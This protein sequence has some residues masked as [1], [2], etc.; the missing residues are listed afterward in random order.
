MLNVPKPKR[1]P[2]LIIIA[3]T[4]VLVIFVSLAASLFGMLILAYASSD[5][6]DLVSRLFWYFID[7][8]AVAVSCF[9]LAYTIYRS[10]MKP[11]LVV[12]FFIPIIISLIMVSIIF[13]R[14]SERISQD[15]E[16]NKEILSFNQDAFKVINSIEQK[17]PALFSGNCTISSGEDIHSYGCTKPQFIKRDANPLTDS[18]LDL[19]KTDLEALIPLK[20][21]YVSVFNKFNRDSISVEIIT[22]DEICKHDPEQ[23]NQKKGIT[24]YWSYQCE[25]KGAVSCDTIKKTRWCF[26]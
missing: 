17:I 19:F 23:V 21:K 4:Y 10:W 20:E 26:L 6:Q 12:V 13:T 18:E 7:S 22:R 24:E 5:T 2:L 9:V 25:I 3:I 15:I 8:S 11:I 1:N 14:G 16:F